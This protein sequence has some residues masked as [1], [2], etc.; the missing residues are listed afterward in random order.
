MIKTKRNRILKRATY[1][2]PRE[3][4]VFI[5]PSGVIRTAQEYGLI[6]LSK[7][8]DDI[9]IEGCSWQG[10]YAIYNFLNPLHKSITDDSD[11]YFML[12][13]VSGEIGRDSALFLVVFHHLYNIFLLRE[14]W[15]CPPFRTPI[16]SKYEYLQR[17]FS[18]DMQVD[19]IEKDLVDIQEFLGQNTY[20]SWAD[21]IKIFV[22]PWSKEGP[23]INHTEEERLA[24][25]SKHCQNGAEVLQ[26]L[27]API[28]SE[29][30]VLDLKDPGPT[31]DG[32][33]NI[34]LEKI[35]Q[36]IIFAQT[37]IKPLSI[38]WIRELDLYLFL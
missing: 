2:R 21:F 28:E 36:H 18:S 8:P 3:Q 29:K 19:L 13:D 31:I 1:R 35:D 20:S 15:T 38:D 17:V 27:L 37:G 22:N 23:V 32:L 14:P 26:F 16:K 11:F 30:I 34:L 4:P 24:A 6:Y 7:L 12:P 33:C 10:A 5:G 25:L 9:S